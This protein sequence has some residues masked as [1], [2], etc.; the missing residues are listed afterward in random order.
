MT[1]DLSAGTLKLAAAAATPQG[2]KAQAQFTLPTSASALPLRLA[3]DRTRPI[4]GRFEAVGEVKPLWRLMVGGERSLTGR[5]DIA[6]NLTGSLSEPDVT[7]RGALE[8]GVFEDGATGLKLQNVSLRTALSQTG[9]DLEMAS[10]DDGEG[11]HVTAAGRFDLRR[12]AE[13]SLKLNLTGFRVIDNALGTASATGQ[14][15]L[16][17]NPDGR[18]MLT[19]GL[20]I[21]RADLSATPPTPSG[22]LVLD[23]IERN[24]QPDLQPDLLYPP[25]RG[26]GMAFDLTLTA[27]RRVFVRGR[28]LDVEMS[29]DAHLTGNSNAPV[30]GGAARVVRG[31]YDFAGKRFEFEDRG[32]VYLAT[33]L[34]LIRLDLTAARQDPALTATVNIRGTAARPE[35]TL[36]SSPALPNDEVLSQVLFGASAAQLSPLEAAQLASALAALSG[37]GGFDVIGNLRNFARLDRLSFAGDAAGG[38][39]IAGGKYFTDDVYLELIGGGREGP[40]A[41]VEWRMRRMLSLVSRLSA[42]Q[43]SRLSVRWRRDY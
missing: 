35:I 29:L 1:A 33:R 20:A 32:V 40:V 6:L 26:P 14:A 7:G 23:V 10:A 27:L 19:G 9:I 25:K 11:G 31:D 16:S 43:D 4:V 15:V 17:R 2:L 28:G 37:G 3:I 38:M 24:R 39:T 34:D 18:L 5:A 41:Q 22:V 12:G 21:D 8:G 42:N 13:S 36:S 30:L